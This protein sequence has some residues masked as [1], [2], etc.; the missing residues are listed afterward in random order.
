MGE[1]MTVLGPI[2]AE[3]LGLTSMHE[4]VLMDGR[5]YRKKLAKRSPTISQS[6]LMRIFHCRTLDC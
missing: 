2:P 4:H 3:D 6:R 1:V 5:V